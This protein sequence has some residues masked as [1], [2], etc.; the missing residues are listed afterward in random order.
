M[1]ILVLNSGSSSLK[2]QVINME[3]GLAMAEGICERIGMEGSVMKYKAD[4]IKEKILHDMPTHKDGID[5]LLETL[6]NEKLGI[7]TSINEIDAIGHR[8]VHGGEKF[9]A[10]V[11]VDAQVLKSVKGLSSLAPLHNPA[12]ALGVEIC[13]ELMPDKPN[14]AVFDTAFHQTMP[15]KAFMYALPYED[16]EELK[17]RKYG[18]HGTSHKYVSNLAGELLGK[19]N[20][21]IIVCHLGNGASVSAVSGGKCLDTSMGLTPLQG[22]MMGTRCGDLDPAA[23][24][25]IMEERGLTIKDMD[26]RMNKESGFL[27]VFGESSDCRD[28]E[29]GIEAGNRRA[30]L[31]YDMFCY[32]VKH[33]IG[34]YASIMGG[35]D[36]V[37][38]TA[39]IGENGPEIR[40]LVCEGLE[41]MGIDFD[42]KEN[43]ER[44]DGV[45]VLSKPD[46]KVKVYK[47][48]TNEEYVI[49][50]DTYNLLK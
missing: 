23:V 4:G 7:I 33:Y 14:V 5:L 36:A 38:F 27:G 48:P 34:A 12:N 10:S 19:E 41:F 32:K 46:S 20:A 45:Q 40:E 8:V 50:E 21:K 18:F 24:L 28:I 30:K 44:K 16:Y 31:A 9:D 39:G 42:R 35:L 37:C 15:E 1:K 25:R 22:L 2:Y 47:I 29:E 17:I 43:S 26:A 13:M 6:E 11:L 3:T 49:A